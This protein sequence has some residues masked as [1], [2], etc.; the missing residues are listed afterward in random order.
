ML[1]Q[2]LGIPNPMISRIKVAEAIGSH[3]FSPMGTNPVQAFACIIHPEII[4]RQL[5]QHSDGSSRLSDVITIFPYW[6]R[7]SI[8]Q[9]QN[10]V[11]QYRVVIIHATEKVYFDQTAH[12]PNS[13]FS[14]V[15]TPSV[16]INSPYLS[17]DQ[18]KTSFKIVYD[19]SFNFNT[20]NPNNVRY[21]L[22][23]RIPTHTVHYNSSDE[24]GTEAYGYY[25]LGV[26]TDAPAQNANYL[27]SQAYSLYF[28][29]I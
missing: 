17:V 14:T 22:R 15:N 24:S 1:R 12:I 26:L 28:L 27:W 13:Y 9:A 11:F 8:Q 3:Q 10:Q 23:F 16:I 21:F 29:G 4:P 6:I 7:L 20:L 25:F 5:A 18:R 2:K 19:K